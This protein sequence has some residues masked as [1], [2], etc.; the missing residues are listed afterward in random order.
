MENNN[1]INNKD[2]IENENCEQ[3]DLLKT[4]K[5]PDNKFVASSIKL[6]KAKYDFNEE[7]NLINNKKNNI[8]L[9]MIKSVRNNYISSVVDYKNFNMKLN[10]HRNII[11]NN[12]RINYSD[13]YSIKK[14]NENDSTND[15]NQRYSNFR[16]FEE[17]FLNKSNYK[18][19]NDDILKIIKLYKEKR[20]N[21]NRKEFNSNNESDFRLYTSIKGGNINKRYL[22]NF[23][24]KLPLMKKTGNFDKF[25]KINEK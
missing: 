23:K 14:Y 22:E 19:R 8:F 17:N 10:N 7:N 12:D 4:I 3:N 1:I 5:I 21:D 9:P 20:S 24:I 18:N 13:I 15:I 2:E 25:I 11:E 6:P 16:S